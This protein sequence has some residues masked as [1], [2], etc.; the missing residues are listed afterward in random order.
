MS[1]ACSLFSLL[2]R[3]TSPPG[4]TAIGVHADGF[5]LATVE[6]GEGER[7]R[8]RACAFLPYDADDRDRQLARLASQRHLKHERCTTLLDGP[9]YQLLLT[10]AP[11]VKPDEVNRFNRLRSITISAASTAVSTR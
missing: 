2:K 3:K 6:R 8:L 9:D 7:P 11:D 5:S 4:L 1:G 10:E